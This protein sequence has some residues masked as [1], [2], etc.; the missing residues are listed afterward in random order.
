MWVSHDKRRLADYELEGVPPTDFELFYPLS[1]TLAVHMDFDAPGRE[2]TRRA[3]SDV[4]TLRYDRMIARVSH[5]QLYG[6]S[7]VDLLRADS[8]AGVWVA[9]SPASLE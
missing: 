7:E 2:T 9:V 3:L 5:Q 8:P 4:E 6:P 1:P